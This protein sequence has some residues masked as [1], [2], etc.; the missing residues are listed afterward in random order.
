MAFDKIR[1]CSES[2]RYLE[3]SL[4]RMRTVREVD[5]KKKR[6]K[7]MPSSSSPFSRIFPLAY[8]YALLDNPF[9]IPTRYSFNLQELSHMKALGSALSSPVGV[10]LVVS[11][12]LL[13]ESNRVL[14][15]KQ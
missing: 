5:L 7:C 10:V 11:A 8:Y 13:V 9:G 14:F 12:N 3:K 6:E 15:E 4:P 1:M 2:V